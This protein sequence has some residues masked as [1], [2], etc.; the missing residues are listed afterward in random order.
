MVPIQDPQ[1]AKSGGGLFFGSGE[2][3]S[4]SKL[5]VKSDPK[6]LAGFGESEADIVEE[7]RVGFGALEAAG[8][9]VEETELGFL[10]IE[11]DAPLV[12]VGEV[13]LEGFGNSSDKDVVVVVG[14]PEGG[15]ISKLG[16]PTRCVS[17]IPGDR[18]RDVPYI[19][20]V[21]ERRNRRALRHACVECEGSGQGTSEADLGGAPVNEMGDPSHDWRGELE[22]K[23]FRS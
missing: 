19:Y 9:E 20:Y 6:I 15:V 4:E 1:G 12:A 21:Q 22:V 7:D 14:N 5:G 11:E 18:S 8:V 16:K 23:E 13:V 17:R 2:V 3:G 10:G